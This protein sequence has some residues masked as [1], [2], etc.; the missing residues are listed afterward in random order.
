MAN[1]DRTRRNEDVEREEPDRSRG[2]DDVIGRADEREDEFEDVDET[3][4]EDEDEE[5]EEDLES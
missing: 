3:D 2:E 4:E 1:D 5:D